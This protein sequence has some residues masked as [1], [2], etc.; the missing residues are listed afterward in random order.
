[1]RACRHCRLIE[2][3]KKNNQCVGCQSHD[4]SEDF[5]GIVIIINYEK[6]EI[7]ERMGI[8]RNGKYAVKVR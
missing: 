2:T 5:S 4:L 7:A 8:T 3:D 1:M 6:S